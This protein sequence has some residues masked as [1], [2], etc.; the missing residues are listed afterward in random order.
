MTKFKEMFKKATMFTNGAYYID[1]DI[2]KDEFIKQIDPE[3]KVEH[4]NETRVRFGFAPDFIEDREDF[5]GKPIWFSGASRKGSKK[6]W[7]YQPWKHIK[8][9]K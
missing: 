9:E 4:I 6:V 8:K 5:E 7:E 3:I 1:A 2:P